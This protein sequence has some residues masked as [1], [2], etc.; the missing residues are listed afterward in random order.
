[1]G[2]AEREGAGVDQVDPWVV[3]DVAGRR[4]LGVWNTHDIRD[5]SARILRDKRTEK[6]RLVSGSRVSYTHAACQG[7]PVAGGS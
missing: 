6:A 1:M 3:D 4:V 5:Q 2:R 7:R